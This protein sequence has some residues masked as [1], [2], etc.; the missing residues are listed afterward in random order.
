MILQKYRAL[1]HTWFLLPLGDLYASTDGPTDLSASNSALH[2]F[3]VGLKLRLPFSSRDPSLRA[4][5]LTKRAEMKDLRNKKKTEREST[6]LFVRSLV[7]IV[8]RKK[9]KN[10][11]YKRGVD[12][13][14]QKTIIV[15]IGNVWFIGNQD[16][17]E[18]VDLIS[19]RK[20]L[21]IEKKPSGITCNMYI[22]IY[23]YIFFFF[24]RRR[25][26]Y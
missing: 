23:I 4:D 6:N 5:A 3:R 24:G 12:F 18:D 7:E 1:H 16:E 21:T 20:V 9:K 14:K 11:S 26:L 8:Y 2:V 17:T 19:V 15:L 10:C 25:Q 22:Y 13:R